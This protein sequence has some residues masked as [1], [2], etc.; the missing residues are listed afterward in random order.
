MSK[1]TSWYCHKINAARI[2]ASSEK[3][4][5]YGVPR[6]QDHDII[7][8]EH[9]QQLCYHL[10]TLRFGRSESMLAENM[11]IVF[12]RFRIYKLNVRINVKTAH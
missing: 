5:P 8:R 9:F 6:V 1:V 11:V 2:A 10:P 7:G 3:P 12:L 4:G